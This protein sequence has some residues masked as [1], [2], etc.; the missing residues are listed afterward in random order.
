MVIRSLLVVAVAAALTGC[1]TPQ[2]R[3]AKSV[4]RF[5]PYCEGLGYK[6]DTDPW[7]SCILKEEARIW[8]D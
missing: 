1:A 5:G 8:S 3:A 2:D 4:V 7:R 6:K